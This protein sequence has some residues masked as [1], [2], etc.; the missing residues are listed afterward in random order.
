MCLLSLF[1][2]LRVF[3]SL[4]LAFSATSLACFTYSFLRYADSIGSGI[5]IRISSLFGL[6]PRLDVI[7]AFSI[8]SIELL[9]YGCTTSILGSGA[10][11]VASWF[12]GVKE[13]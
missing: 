8:D 7:I 5:R 10:V 12:N 1:A 11:T 13:P 3:L 6:S 4:T 2:A 9:S